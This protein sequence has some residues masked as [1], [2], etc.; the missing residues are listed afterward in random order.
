MNELRREPLLGRW[1]VVLK[2][3]LAPDRY[4]PLVEAQSHTENCLFCTESKG[5]REKYVV[6]DDS[7]R[8]KVKVV[9]TDDSVFTLS[10]DLGR[11]GVGMYDMMNSVGLLETVIESS[12]HN[13]PPEDISEE[14]MASV[15]NTF[16]IRIL[17]IEKDPRIRY[18]MIHKNS[19]APSGD[20]FGH[21]HSMITATPVIPKRIKEELDG[22][23]NY[24]DYK[25]RCIFC[26]IMREEERAGE[27]VILTTEHFIVFAPFATRFPFEFWIMPRRHNCSF[28]DSSDEERSDL[29]RVMRRMLRGLR[30][31]LK[32]PPYN[33]VVHTAPSRIPRMAQWHTLGE[34]FH[35]HIEVM[36]RIRR[37]SGFEL[38][39]GMYTLT[40]SPEDAAKYLKEE[41]EDGD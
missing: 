25:E 32:D 7:G 21:P 11:R 37:L 26:D 3:S 41:V 12:E 29:A 9:E 28:K 38:G 14:H 10:G 15:I 33:Y 24:Y 22:A 27:R 19:G 30:R 20:T 39:S 13:T 17:E 8:W 35:W 36:P 40:T 1:V 2:E 18:I 6:N 5:M 34:D 23:K 31:L 16:H 4:T